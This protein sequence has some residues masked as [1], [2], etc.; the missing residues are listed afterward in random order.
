MP[1]IIKTRVDRWELPYFH[2]ISSF[3]LNFQKIE[4]DNFTIF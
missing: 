3:V 4:F 2:K 1:Y